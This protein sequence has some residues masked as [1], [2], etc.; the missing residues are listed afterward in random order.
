MPITLL[1]LVSKTE[2]LSYVCTN[3]GSLCAVQWNIHVH[4]GNHICSVI[5]AK[6]VYSAHYHMI[7]CSDFICGTYICQFGGHNCV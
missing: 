5:Y 1:L 6:Y 2:C 7:D 4:F 3:V